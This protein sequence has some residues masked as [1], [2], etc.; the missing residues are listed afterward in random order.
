ME[1]TPAPPG[2]PRHLGAPASGR[3]VRSCHRTFPCCRGWIRSRPTTMATRSLRPGRL[4]AL[5][6]E[7]PPIKMKDF[8]PVCPQSVRG[9]GSPVWRGHPAKRRQSLANPSPRQRQGSGRGSRKAPWLCLGPSSS[10]RSSIISAIPSLQGAGRS[11]L[12]QKPRGPR[13][14]N[15]P[16][17]QRSRYP[18]LGR[19]P[20]CRGR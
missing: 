17:P 18:R 2:T 19:P 10:T 8:Q 7:V 6:A 14:N 4:S 16:V 20:F 11:K 5:P 3:R 15:K 13:G 12:T 9:P 1:L